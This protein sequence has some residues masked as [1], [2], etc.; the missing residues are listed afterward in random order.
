MGFV[1]FLNTL[2]Q[3]AHYALRLLVK[4]PGFTIIAVLTLALGIGAN[5]AIFSL[6]DAVMFRALPVEDPQRLVLLQWNANK[7]PEFRMYV[8][9]GDTKFT[10]LRDASNPTGNSFSYPF[11]EQVQKS[12]VFAGVAAFA[13]G[14]SLTLTGNC[15]ATTVSNQSVSGDFFHTFGIH[16]AAGRLLEPGDDQPSSAPAVV[17][18]YGYWQRAFGGSPSAIGK[19]INLNGIA[20]TVV[21]VAEKK[22]VSLSLGNVFDTWIPFAMAN[23]LNP[24]FAHRNQDSA[25]WWVLIAARLKPGATADQA[26][27]ALDVLFK[28]SVLHSEKPVSKEADAPH[29]TLPRAQDALIGASAQYKDP[30]RVLTVAV[31]IVLL[32]ACANVAGL[33]LSRATGRRREIAVRLALGA[34]RS[35]LLRQLL[36]ESMVLGIFGGALGILLAFWGAHTIVSMVASGR[37]RP[38]GFTATVDWRVL[39]FTG[40]VSVLTGIL[41]GLAPALRSLRL[42]LTPTLKDGSGASI[43]GKPE[44][45]HRWFSLSNGLVVIQTSLAIVVLM[46]AALL[47]RTL[48]NLKDLNPGFDTRTTLTFG[49]NPRPAGYK[50]PQIDNLYRE[51]QGQIGG[52][53]GVMAVSYSQM[54]L[55]S[56]GWGRIVF[57]YRPPGSAKKVQVEADDMPVGPDFFNTVK[58]PLVAGRALNSADYERAAKQRDPFAPPDASPAPPN[59]PLP[60]VVNQVFARKYF[61][62][63]NPIGQTFGEN[64]GSDP[65]DPEKDPGNV[66]VGVVQDAKYNDLRRA[67]DPTMY[68]PLSGQ[69][70]TFE[71]R[72]AGDPTAMVPA[73][74]NLI[75]QHDANL[76][77]NNVMTQSEQIDQLLQQERLIAKLSSFFGVLALLLACVGLYGLLSYEVTR[78]T[79]EIGIRMALGA[80]RADLVRLVVLRGF[81]LALIGTAIGIAAAFGAGRLLSTLLFGVKA[82]DPITMVFVTLLLVVVAMLAAFVPARR[83]TTVDPMIAL[84]YE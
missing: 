78:R 65:K 9:T 26:Q 20:F 42:D 15:P 59:T 74:R 24:A 19:V 77:L 83:A 80:Q 44:S 69:S 54:A 81:A 7:S 36:T 29:I 16:A 52:L 51:L 62:G 25:A 61:P 53:P 38:L 67:I 8:V 17:L 60:V 82:G 84:R 12:N 39:A 10:R 50:P 47:V 57:D 22:F 11:L 43:G 14:G 45:R 63:V 4:A 18:N 49:L 58:I 23:R 46:G 76:P 1:E 37:T 41:F 48:T 72:T 31:A 5:T 6:M 33:V 66:I 21:G 64:D 55:L 30:L 75:G 3:D 13:G 27:A 79:R 2:R 68:V 73:I 70:A 35:R 32:I 28:N 40:A 56:G 34:R 71:V